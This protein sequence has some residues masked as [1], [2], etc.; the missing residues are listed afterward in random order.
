M[1]KLA[2]LEHE[3]RGEMAASLGRVGARLEALL[4]ELARLAAARPDPRVVA[5]HR[6]V[7]AR[8]ELNLW[9]LVVQRE[10]MGLR[11]HSRL[12]EQYVIPP[13]LAAAPARAAR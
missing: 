8:A 12:R 13:P 7:R 6:A 2:G 1:N 10:A 4:A 3:I 11:D 9:Y 5:E